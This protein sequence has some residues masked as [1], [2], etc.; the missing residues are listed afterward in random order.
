[1][2]Y[3][4]AVKRWEFFWA[5]LDFP[6]GSEQGG[7]RRPVLVVSNDGFNDATTLVTILPLTKLEGKRRKVY[8]HEVLL[9]AEILGTGV[10][11]IVM[12]QQIRTI[13]KSRLLERM[14]SLHDMDKRDEII[15]RLLEHLDIEFE[16][17][18]P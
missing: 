3:S 11:S 5:D 9:P 7:N 17:E 6:V 13:S 15:N 4:A 1:M 16:A 12:P 10:S 18:V 14:G 8:T 2:A